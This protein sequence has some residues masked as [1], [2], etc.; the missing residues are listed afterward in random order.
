MC[1]APQLPVAAQPGYSLNDANRDF[2]GLVGNI[3]TIGVGAAVGG[4]GAVAGLGIN[5]MSQLVNIGGHMANKAW[6]TP[7]LQSSPS[8]F[9]SVD[10]NGC[11]VFSAIAAGMTD[12][13]I[14][15]TDN[16][17]D[18]YGYAMEE[19]MAKNDINDTNGAYLQVGSEYCSG[20]EAD[21]EIN[22]RLAN[23]IKIITSF[24]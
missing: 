4:I 2:M 1:L 7:E 17:L 6:A 8:S 23:G 19:E 16:Y 10:K 5:L 11:I 15:V 22:T 20:S 3:A 13:D 14:E 24:T 9:G 12:H 21:V 18:Y